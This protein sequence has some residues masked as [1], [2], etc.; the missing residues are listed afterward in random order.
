MF[1]PKAG[2]EVKEMN[3]ILVPEKQRNIPKIKQQSPMKVRVNAKELTSQ[4]ESIKADDGSIAKKEQELTNK[5]IELSQREDVLDI[6][7]VEDENK[8]KQDLLTDPTQSQR[9]T[10]G[11]KRNYKEMLEGDEVMK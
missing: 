1:F 4:Q 3:K 7:I 2:P 10:R 11:I 9:R 8:L 5:A 6:L